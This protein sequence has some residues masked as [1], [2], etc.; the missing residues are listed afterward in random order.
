MLY[1]VGLDLHHIVIDLVDLLLVLLPARGQLC[2]SDTTVTWWM[3][4]G[5]S[6]TDQS[7]PSFHRWRA[8]FIQA[9][10]MPYLAWREAYVS[11][12]KRDDSSERARPSSSGAVNDGEN[13]RSVSER[14]GMASSRDGW[15]FRLS[16]LPLALNRSENAWSRERAKPENYPSDGRISSPAG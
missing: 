6:E 12:G 11:A 14:A 5:K 4:G 1:A 15:R 10:L 8:F 16:G 3:W 2:V 7:N 13:G 9:C